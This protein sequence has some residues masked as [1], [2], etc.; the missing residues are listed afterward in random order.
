MPTLAEQWL[1]QGEAIGLEK[2]LEKGREEG[3]EKGLEEGREAALNI[4]R[5]FVARRFGTALEHFDAEL[6]SLDLVS[7]TALSDVAFAAESL[8][9]FEAALARLTSPPSR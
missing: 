1:A 9:E 2:G 4:L 5:R 6:T 3:L 8:A 7:I